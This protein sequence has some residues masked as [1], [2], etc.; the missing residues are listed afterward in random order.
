[1]DSET[2]YCDSCGAVRSPPYI[3]NGKCPVGQ[4]WGYV[5]AFARFPTAEALH[6]S[7]DADF[8]EDWADYVVGEARKRGFYALQNVKVK[9]GAE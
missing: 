2:G 3:R 4:C 9:G 1:M 5:W 7:V 8:S 6:Q